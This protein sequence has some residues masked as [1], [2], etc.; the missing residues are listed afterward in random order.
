MTSPTAPLQ[1]AIGQALEKFKAD[2][3]AL[4]SSKRLSQADADAVYALAWNAI[5]QGRNQDAL[6]YFALL[7]LYRPTN[8][9]YLTG[10]ALAF[11]RLKLFDQAIVAYSF[12][13]VLDPANPAHTLAVGEC[14]LLKRELH[15]G[16]ET[17]AL[18]VRF[19]KE[20]PGH[21]KVQARALGLMELTRPEGARDAS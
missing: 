8:T 10:Q 5:A 6:R 2:L 16:R 7:L 15:A 17:L 12:L 20:N 3:E 9:V 11:Q 14:Q 18:V 1:H 21:D 4:P 19:C 13:G